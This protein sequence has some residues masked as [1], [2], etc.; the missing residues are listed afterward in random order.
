MLQGFKNITLESSEKNYDF[1]TAKKPS[2][3]SEEKVEQTRRRLAS[4]DQDSVF[5]ESKSDGQGHI[6]P[7]GVQK[8]ILRQT[9]TPAKNS[10]TAAL[11]IPGWKFPALSTIS[12]G[13]KSEKQSGRHQSKKNHDSA[14]LHGE[15]IENRTQNLSPNKPIPGTSNFGAGKRENYGQKLDF[16]REVKLGMDPLQA[17]VLLVKV[18]LNYII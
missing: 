18:C 15:D 5:V 13:K 3:D 14:D 8:S 6:S 1:G 10:S 12:S 4:N 7:K 11:P 2:V 16:S 17:C 9:S